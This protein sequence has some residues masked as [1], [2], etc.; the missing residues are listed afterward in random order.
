[1]LVK[2]FSFLAIVLALSF[3]WTSCDDDDKDDASK[4]TEFQTALKGTYVP[5]FTAVGMTGDKWDPYWVECCKIYT[6][7]DEEAAKNST[8]YLQ[9][10]MTSTIYGADAVSKYG[11]ELKEGSEF[12]FNCDFINGVAKLSFNGRNIRQI[13]RFDF[14]HEFR[15][16]QE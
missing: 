7:G 8:S 9:Y 14:W 16:I 10:I 11:T 1:M 5:L 3:A 12:R 15:Q 6:D 4:P 13:F 2:K